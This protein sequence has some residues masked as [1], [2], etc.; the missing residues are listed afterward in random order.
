MII[1]VMQP[2]LF[3]YLGYYQMIAASDVF[4][5]YTTVDYIQRGWINRNRILKN[6]KPVYFTAPVV[7]TPLGTLINEVELVDYARF[8]TSFLDSI[9]Q[10]YKKAPHGKWL[11]QE[12]ED[13]LASVDP[14]YIYEL[15]TASLVWSCKLLGIN[16]EIVLA[17]NLKGMQ[18]DS[19][20]EKLA[21]VIEATAAKTLLLPP[22][23]IKLYRDWESAA[24]K[25]FLALPD[26]IYP[27]L[28]DEYHPYLSILDTL[29]SV[30]PEQTIK[31]INS[32]S[33]Q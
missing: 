28:A 11:I 14:K 2:Y 20:E 9:K 7:K 15:A 13:F 4:V 21:Y 3:P 30:G 6:G 32:P 31:A 22:S 26:F 12:L 10:A 17:H 16:T 27:Q 25:R 5:S 19:K 23:S 33:W 29:A 1:S 18:G 8:R 24:N